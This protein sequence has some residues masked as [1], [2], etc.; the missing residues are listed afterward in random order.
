MGCMRGARHW[1]VLYNS[2]RRE[3]RKKENRQ[4][5]GGMRA[6]GAW[7]MERIYNSFSRDDPTYYPGMVRHI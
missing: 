2:T 5:K 3:K 7:S 1:D 4:P 6:L